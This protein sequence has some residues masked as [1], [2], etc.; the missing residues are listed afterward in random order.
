MSDKKLVFIG[1]QEE[2]SLDLTNPETVVSAKEIANLTD[3]SGLSMEEIITAAKGGQPLDVEPPPRL[4]E[5][6]PRFIA[7]D[8]CQDPKILLQEKFSNHLSRCSY[9][10]P[11]TI[12]YHLPLSQKDK[13]AEEKISPMVFDRFLKFSKG[14]KEPLRNR[15]RLIPQNH[16]HRQFQKCRL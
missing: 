4:P 2:S 13:Q 15:D 14:E 16:S 7:F 8:P 5:N 11:V 12:N 3:I 1:R 9:S 10:S 6:P